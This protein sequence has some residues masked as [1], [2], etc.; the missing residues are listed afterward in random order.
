MA[1]ANIYS[2]G[3]WISANQFESELKLCNWYWPFWLDVPE[4]ACSSNDEIDLQQYANMRWIESD[5][6]VSNR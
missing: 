2:N 6:F 1:D 3:V 4:S 5:S